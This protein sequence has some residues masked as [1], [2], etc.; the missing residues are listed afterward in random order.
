MVHKDLE[1]FKKKLIEEQALLEEELS[2]LGRKNP[3]NPDDWETTYNDPDQANAK[4]PDELEA[5]DNLQAYRIEDYE[6]RFATRA[7][8]EAR[9]NN[10]KRAL[11]RMEGHTYGFCPVNGTPHPIERGRLEANPAAATC[12]VHI[13]KEIE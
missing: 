6:L 11:Q 12:K 5:D 13:T 8:L 2:H 9:L 10:V 3:K 4:N 1:Y 7:P